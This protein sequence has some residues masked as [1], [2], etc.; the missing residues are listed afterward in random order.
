VCPDYCAGEGVCLGCSA[1]ELMG[2]G[3]YK[4]SCVQEAVGMVSGLQGPE[5]W[6]GINQP[7]DNGQVVA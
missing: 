4:N 7:N 3:E 5:P 6:H 1:D 2:E